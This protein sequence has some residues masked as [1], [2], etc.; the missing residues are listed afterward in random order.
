[1]SP[2]PT[3]LTSLKTWGGQRTWQPPCPLLSPS[4][5]SQEPLPP[6]RAVLIGSFRTCFQPGSRLHFRTCL[7]IKQ[8]S[9]ARAWLARVGWDRELVTW[10]GERGIP[11]SVM[12][13]GLTHRSRFPQLN[14]NSCS[15]TSALRNRGRDREKSNLEGRFWGWVRVL[16][17]GT[18][19]RA[20]RGRQRG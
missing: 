16:E 10:R 9:T 14:L 12:S 15:L 2:S 4:P 8:A 1:M 6:S 7:E 3:A 18:G 5:N 11:F 13:L 19:V 17:E 20:S